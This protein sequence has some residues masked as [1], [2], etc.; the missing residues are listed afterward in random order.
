MFDFETYNEN[1]FEW[2]CRRRF[3]S[4]ITF[5]VHL[6]N[7]VRFRL[8]WT[9]QELH[10][11]LAVWFVVT[12]WQETSLN[13][14]NV[15]SGSGRIG[16][17]SIPMLFETRSR[18]R[19]FDGCDV[20]ARVLW[21]VHGLVVVVVCTAGTRCSSPPRPSASCSTAWPV[22]DLRSSNEIGFERSCFKIQS[23]FC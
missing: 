12:E 4:A 9:R 18:V 21:V 8:V 13:H 23:F 7:R 3:F 19:P 20:S 16:L 14:S 2:R 1:L 11:K 17:D 6:Q 15:R 22:A 10:R 5:V